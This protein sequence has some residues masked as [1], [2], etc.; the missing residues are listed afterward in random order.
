MRNDCRCWIEIRTAN[1]V[2]NLRRIRRHAG[3]AA[4]LVVIKNNAYGIGVREVVRALA[5]SGEAAR[6]GVASLAE[7]I[8]IA[9]FGV[10]VQIISG[11]LPAEIPEAVDRGFI[12]P[13][14]SVEAARLISAEATRRNRTPHVELKTDVG[15]GRVGLRHETFDDELP[16]ILKLHNLACRGIFAHLPVSGIPDDPLTREEIAR[17]KAIIARWEAKGVRFDFRHIAASGAICCYPEATAAPFN[18]IRPGIILHGFSAAGGLELLP[19]TEFKARVIAIRELPA[20][21][22]L[23]YGRQYRM[24]RRGRV[25]VVSAGYADGVPIALTNRGV[26]LVGGSPAPVVGRVSMDYTMVLLPDDTPEPIRVGDE[27]VLFGEQRGRRAPMEEWA[28]IKGVPSQD[29]LCS[30]GRRPERVYL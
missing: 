3:G 5:A 7:A 27:V 11:I 28:R 9:D 14:N 20:G 17:L 6:F 21:A 12:L 26:F 22:T 29:I 10:P 25:A 13:V 16:E 15:M 18:M 8:E 24:P 4:A 2:E 19:G 1:L 30:L 23:G